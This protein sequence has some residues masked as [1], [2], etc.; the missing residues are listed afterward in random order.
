MRQPTKKQLRDRIAKLQSELFRAIG[1]LPDGELKK[2]LVKEYPDY[3][4]IAL[5]DK[6]GDA[7]FLDILS[8]MGAQPINNTKEFFWFEKERGVTSMTEPGGPVTI[9]ITKE[10]YGGTESV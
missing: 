1:Q 6:Y 10:N 7:S 9:T 3:F 5:T 2:R 8:E 4:F